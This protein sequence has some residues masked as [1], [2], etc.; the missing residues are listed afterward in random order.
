MTDCVECG[1]KLGLIEGY[2]HPTMGKE[3]LICSRCFDSVSV[4]VEQ[5]QKVVSWYAGFFH[6]ETTA[7]DDLQRIGHYLVKKLHKGT[8]T[9]WSQKTHDSD[10]VSTV[11]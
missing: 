9:L 5:W 11:N 3:H 6:T 1:K 10:T 8:N 2:R 7:Q 4:S